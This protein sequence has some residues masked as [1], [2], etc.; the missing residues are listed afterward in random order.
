MV[1]VTNAVHRTMSM[2]DKSKSYMM[3]LTYNLTARDIL[4]YLHELGHSVHTRS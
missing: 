1:E 4:V 2:A 3:G